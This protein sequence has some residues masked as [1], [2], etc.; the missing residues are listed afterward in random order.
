MTI[1][2]DMHDAILNIPARAWTPAYD[3]DRQARDGA[4]VAELTGML[5]LTT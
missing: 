2:G 1:T 4:W 3:S 5:N